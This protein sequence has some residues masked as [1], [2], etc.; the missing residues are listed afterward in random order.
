MFVRN[1]MSAPAVAI[2]P[3]ASAG[4]ALESMEKR[5]IRRLPV[6]A[7]GRLVGIVTK[8]DLQDGRGSLRRPAA[9]TVGDVMSPEP[10]TVDPDEPLETATKRMLDR[11]ISGLPVL[12]GGK[13]VG[14]ITESDLFRALASM[15]GIGEKG[16]RILMTVRDDGDLLSDVGRR[17]NG[18]AVRSLVTV[19]DPK[20]KVWDVVLRARGRAPRPA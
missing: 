6:M 20:R 17:L 4:A 19:H 10:V 9:L 8:S 14:I 1:W 2:S 15:L 18:L 7:D 13:L 12:D 5:R 16:A 11:K 3:G